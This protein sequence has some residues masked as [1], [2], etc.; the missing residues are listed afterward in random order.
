MPIKRTPIID[1]SSGRVIKKWNKTKN[2]KPMERAYNVQRH[3]RGHGYYIQYI[4]ATS[5]EEAIQKA[6]RDPYRNMSGITW[7]FEMGDIDENISPQDVE[8]VD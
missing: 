1:I 2:T 3:T 7:D 4:S 6:R 5:E 8:E